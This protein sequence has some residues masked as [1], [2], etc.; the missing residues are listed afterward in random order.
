G[1]TAV[2]DLDAVPRVRGVDDVARAAGVDPALLACTGGEDYHLLA[3]LPPEAGREPH[4]QVVGHIQAG[5]PG[6]RAMRAGR[7]VTPTRLG[8]EHHARGSASAE[9]PPQG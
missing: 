1:L 8:W 6:V 5:T 2:I 9:P 3:A 4:L 7:D